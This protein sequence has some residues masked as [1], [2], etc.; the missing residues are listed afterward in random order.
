[1]TLLL[2]CICPT[3]RSLRAAASWEQLQI[4]HGIGSGPQAA[5]ARKEG[6]RLGQHGEQV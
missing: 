1:M 6:G 4:A 3:Q 2:T 5:E